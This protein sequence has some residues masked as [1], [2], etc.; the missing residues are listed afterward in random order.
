[1]CCSTSTYLKQHVSHSCIEARESKIKDYFL[2]GECPLLPIWSLVFFW[3]RDYTV[4]KNGKGIRKVNGTI[5]CSQIVQ[6]QEFKNKWNGASL[7]S[8]AIL[9]YI[10]PF[11]NKNV[12]DIIMSSKSQYLSH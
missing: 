10:N 7:Y 9:I 2:L 6:T 11:I 12:H 4:L 1:M 3:Q 5:L 8:Q